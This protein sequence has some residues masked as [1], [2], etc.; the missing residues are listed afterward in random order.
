MILYIGFESLSAFCMLLWR[1]T[2]PE[3]NSL[4]L[5]NKP[6]QKKR[7]LHLPTIDFQGRA[8]SFREGKSQVSVKITSHHILKLKWP[9]L[10]AP[11]DCHQPLHKEQNAKP[12][13]NSMPPN[14]WD[15]SIGS[16]THP[17]RVTTRIVTF[18]V[19]DP[20]KP[21]FANVTGCGVDPT[22]PYHCI[23]P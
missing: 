10:V 11:A 3:T 21:S 20:Y 22:N 18:L 9:N 8:A 19:G 6:G 23:P 5:K 12:F 1:Y 7:N 17:V 13:E 16:T 2:L 15:R 4:P 14:F